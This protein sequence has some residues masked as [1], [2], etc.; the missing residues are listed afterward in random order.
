M[1]AGQCLPRHRYQAFIVCG[2][3][4]TSRLWTHQDRAVHLVASQ[5]LA[6]F[7]H[8]DLQVLGKMTG[9]NLLNRRRLITAVQALSKVCSCP[10]T[11]A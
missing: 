6:E 1:R 7:T 2:G 8:D 4:E 11:R 10:I 9:L 5:D 3:V